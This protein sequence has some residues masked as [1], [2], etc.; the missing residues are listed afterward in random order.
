C[1]DIL[2]CVFHLNR[3][4]LEVY[5][6][7]NEIKKARVGTLAKTLG[8]E[9]ST[10]YRSLQRLVACGLCSKKTMTIKTGGYYHV[11]FCS[12]LKKVKNRIEDC[13]DEWYRYMKQNIRDFEKKIKALKK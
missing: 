5:R 10:V 8:K 3:L 13:I 9:R 1:Q 2:E 4:D 6:K 11:Y 12:D 7:L